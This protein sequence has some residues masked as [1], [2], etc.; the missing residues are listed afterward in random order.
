M[1][2]ENPDVKQ[3][4]FNEI[5]H[6]FDFFYWPNKEKVSLLFQNIM[7]SNLT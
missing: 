5:K 3:H 1:V 6:N 7:E 2:Y 4:R